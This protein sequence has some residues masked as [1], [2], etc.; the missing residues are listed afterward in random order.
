M[1]NRWVRVNAVT[2]IIAFAAMVNSCSMPD[3]VLMPKPRAG[4]TLADGYARNDTIRAEA[5]GA[6]I[7]VR[8][9]WHAT[10]GYFFDLVVENKSPADIRFVPGHIGLRGAKIGGVALSAP[11]SGNLNEV[12]A[13]EREGFLYPAD[14][15]V[16]EEASAI[17]VGPNERRTFGYRPLLRLKDDDGAVEAGDSV[18]LR[19]PAKLFDG[20]GGV[21]DLIFAFECQTTDNLEVIPNAAPRERPGS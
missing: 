8:G 6:V 7:S 10:N 12:Q 3:G 17:V 13:R 9:R 11:K 2:L 4:M 1:I 18:E 5:G 15:E 14:E 20:K 21:E 16:D 19:I